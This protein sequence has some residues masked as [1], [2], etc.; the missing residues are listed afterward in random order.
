MTGREELDLLW[1]NPAHWTS[2][3][4]YRC[5]SD[6]RLMVLKREAAGYTIN[7]AHRRSWIILAAL[8]TVSMAPMVVQLVLGRRVPDWMLLVTLLTPIAM[9]VVVLLWLSRR[10]SH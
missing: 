8:L 10:D 2:T 4:R 6:P 7:V 9:V 5:A 1:S 3:G